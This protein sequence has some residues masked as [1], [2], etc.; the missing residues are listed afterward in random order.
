V[1]QVERLSGIRPQLRHERHG[2]VAGDRNAPDPTVEVE[3]AGLAR[4]VG[5]GKV[6]SKVRVH[7]C[8]SGFGDDFPVAIPVEAVHEHAVE[9]RHLAHPLYRHLK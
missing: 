4:Y 8:R 6:E 5:L 2:S 7:A 9:A 3:R 1:S